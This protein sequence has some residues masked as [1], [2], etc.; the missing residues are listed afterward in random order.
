MLTRCS[1]HDE[2]HT[3]HEKCT[4]YIESSKISCSRQEV[5]KVVI[6]AW[7]KTKHYMP[8]SCLTNCLVFL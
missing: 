6:H 8:F 1:K 2:C 5:D 7:K 3:E 4:E